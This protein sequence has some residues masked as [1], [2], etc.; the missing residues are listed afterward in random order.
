[1]K[2]FD[3][4][5]KRHQRQWCRYRHHW[6]TYS[7]LDSDVHRQQVEPG[8]PRIILICFPIQ[9]TRI[10]DTN[11]FV[12]EQFDRSPTDEMGLCDDPAPAGTC[13]TGFNIPSLAVAE[14]VVHSDDSDER[15]D[16]T[17]GAATLQCHTDDRNSCRTA[18]NA[19]SD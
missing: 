11:V 5:L 19:L 16:F 15:N 14:D 10:V 6:L 4:W 1:M 13:T 12:Q 7:A 3:Q 2:N 18:E 17:P 8:E 9:L